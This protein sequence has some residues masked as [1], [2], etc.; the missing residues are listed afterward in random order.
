VSVNG[1]NEP[2]TR[3]RGFQWIENRRTD[4]VDALA[5]LLI[6]GGLT[7]PVV[8]PLLTSQKAGDLVDTGGLF[9]AAGAALLG[10]NR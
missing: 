8:V 10:F 9:V 2:R 4:F 1:S 7:C 3:S 6:L 5:I